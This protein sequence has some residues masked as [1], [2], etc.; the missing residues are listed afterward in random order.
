MGCCASDVVPFTQARAKLS[1]LAVPPESVTPLTGGERPLRLA[2]T[3]PTRCPGAS[4][5]RK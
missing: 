5:D 3:T 1:E 4:S 2:N